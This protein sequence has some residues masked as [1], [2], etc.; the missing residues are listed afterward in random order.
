MATAHDEGSAG[1][2]RAPPATLVIFGASGDLTTRKLIPALQRLAD[3]KRLPEEFAVVGV[4]R[5]ELADED[6][7]RRFSGGQDGLAGAAQYLSGGY[8]DPATYTRQWTAM[9]PMTN[10]PD[11]VIFEYACHEGNY[12]IRNV[13][14]GARVQ[15]GQ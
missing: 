1:E 3:H 15:D 12:S 7:Q 10:L 13:L 6:F 11:Y 9:L 5:S 8:D 14:S 4:G 2:R